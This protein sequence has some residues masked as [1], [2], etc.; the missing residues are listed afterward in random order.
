MWR[1]SPASRSVI[2]PSLPVRPNGA[3]ATLTACVDAIKPKK[4]IKNVHKSHCRANA[5]S[6][7]AT[8][9]KEIQ[10]AIPH[11]NNHRQISC[12]GF[13]KFTVEDVGLVFIPE[14]RATKP[15]VLLMK[16]IGDKRNLKQF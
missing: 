16:R 3:G 7:L 8:L 2:E 9:S 15:R 10:N 11:K 6:P 1:A 14:P 5:K 4:I 13:W 12:G